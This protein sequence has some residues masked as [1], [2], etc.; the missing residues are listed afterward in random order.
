MTSRLV[1]RHDAF[2]NRAVNRGY[3]GFIG[4]FRCSFVT[5]FDGPQHGFDA[6][7]DM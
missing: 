5:G 2:G 7:A 6:G 1:Q 3:G 4:S